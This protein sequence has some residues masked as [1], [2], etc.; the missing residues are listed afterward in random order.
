VTWVEREWDRNR[1]LLRLGF[2][3]K[4]AYTSGNF[5][6][7]LDGCLAEFERKSL[8]FPVCKPSTF[9]ISSDSGLEIRMLISGALVNPCIFP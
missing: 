6:S 2:L 1:N 5:G 8:F 9:R 4:L 7:I 3:P